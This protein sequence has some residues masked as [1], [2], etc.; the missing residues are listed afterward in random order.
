MKDCRS[1]Q[2]QFFKTLGGRPQLERLFEELPDVYFFAKDLAGRFVL[3]NAATLGA[4][5][6]RHADEFLGRT[7]FDIVPREIAEQYREADRMVFTSAKPVRNLVEPVPDAKGTL[8]WFVTSKIPLFDVK[9]AVAGVAIAMRDY[10]HAGNI[11]GPYQAMA[12]V[13]DHIYRYYPEIIS[14]DR[15]AEI[16][17]LSVRQFERRFK[18][19]FHV[20]PLNYVN[21]H[22]IRAAC[23]ALRTTEDPVSAIALKSGFYDHSHFVRQFQ[24]QIGMAP[25][26]YRKQRI[27]NP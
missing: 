12:A 26:E 17:H 24:K 7:D 21:R 8:N 16:A 3:C 13:I 2:N 18:K 19:L 4:L 15:L 20:S 23:I 9:G 1:L 25:T 27:G 14:L 10:R 5:G 6:L 22:R 11:L